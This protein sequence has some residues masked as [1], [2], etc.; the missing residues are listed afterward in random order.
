[1]IS[2]TSFRMSLIFT[3]GENSKN[4]YDNKMIVTDVVKVV[5]PSFGLKGAFERVDLNRKEFETLQD[6]YLAEQMTL[7][8]H[9]S[10]NDDASKIHIETARMLLDKMI[11]PL[12]YWLENK[13]ACNRLNTGATKPADPHTKKVLEQAKQAKA[14]EFSERVGTIPEGVHKRAAERVATRKPMV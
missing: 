9:I 11:P 5:V 1:M 10:T 6:D 12:Q 3:K 2:S 14:K 8:E 4:P 13:F 7:L